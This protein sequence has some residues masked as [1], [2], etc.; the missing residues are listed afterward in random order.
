MQKIPRGK[1]HQTLYKKMG[2]LIDEGMTPEQVI[3]VIGVMNK[4]RCDPPLG[5]G[6]LKH[7][8]RNIHT[9]K[10]RGDVNA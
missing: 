3:K 9:W 8:L 10:P 7:L 6:N 5:D 2:E 4:E 1:R